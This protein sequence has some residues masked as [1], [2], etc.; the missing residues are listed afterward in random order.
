ML[1][2]RRDGFITEGDFADRK[3]ELL[4][5][6]SFHAQALATRYGA[7]FSGYLSVEDGRGT[8]R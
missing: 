8:A 2:G 4:G 7:R 1:R 5:R 6:L 3:A